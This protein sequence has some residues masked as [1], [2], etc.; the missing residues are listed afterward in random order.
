MGNSKSKSKNDEQLLNDL[1]KALKN[2]NESN[3]EDIFTKLRLRLEQDRQ[4]NH[5]NRYTLAKEY[6]SDG[7]YLRESNNYGNSMDETEFYVQISECEGNPITELLKYSKDLNDLSKCPKNCKCSIHRVHPNSPTNQYSP[8][9]DYGNVGN[10]D[11]FSPTS[12]YRN[13]RGSN[14]GSWFS[15]N[16]GYN[17]YNSQSTYDPYSAMNGGVDIDSPTSDGFYGGYNDNQ[18]MYGGYPKNEDEVE[19]ITDLSSD[20]DDLSS[21]DEESDEE[22]SEFDEISVGA[23]STEELERLQSKVYQSTDDDY[24]DTP[25]NFKH[26]YNISN[27][28]AKYHDFDSSVKGILNM[29]KNRHNPKYR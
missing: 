12:D 14:Y 2:K 3:V 15:M 19:I 11:T 6:T 17:P 4:A 21:D 24:S 7:S 20:N 1:N 22:S 23:I 18:I 25:Q 29:S 10:D 8:T 9:S 5:H 26:V 28:K 13:P 16:G 27:R